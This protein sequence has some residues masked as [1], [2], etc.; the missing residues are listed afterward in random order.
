MKYKDELVNEIIEATLAAFDT[1]NK[2]E[3]TNDNEEY[4]AV[5]YLSAAAEDRAR[6]L[7]EKYKAL[8]K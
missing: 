2:L 3:S 7:I 5:L 1:Y 6:Y 4:N 8:Y